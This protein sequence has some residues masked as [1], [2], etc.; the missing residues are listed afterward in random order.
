MRQDTREF[1]PY[2]KTVHALGDFSPKLVPTLLRLRSGE[3]ALVKVVDGDELLQL[4]VYATE[5]KLRDER[6]TLVSIQNIQSE[7]E[8]M[9]IEAWQKLTRVLTHEIMNSVMI[10]R[11]LIM[12]ESS[13]LQ[14]DDFF[15]AGHFEVEEQDGL[16]FDNYNLEEV[17]K[18]VIRPALVK[19]C[20]KSE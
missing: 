14:P 16:I 8:E 1:L 11:A 5:F 9:E 12:T 10:E 4:V 19:L 15:F 13:V 6:Y 7:L 20:E 3:K 2:L 18:I 17:E